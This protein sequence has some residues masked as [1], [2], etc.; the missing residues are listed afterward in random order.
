MGSKIIMKV[1]VRIISLIIMKKTKWKKTIT[2][3]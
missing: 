3:H 1:M 2:N